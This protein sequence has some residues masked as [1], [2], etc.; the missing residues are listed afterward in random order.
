MAFVRYP[1]RQ[2]SPLILQIANIAGIAA[3]TVIRYLSYRQWVFP[4]AT[5]TPV[6][7]VAGD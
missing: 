6:P 7:S 2:E 4:A 1:L 5:G 3:G